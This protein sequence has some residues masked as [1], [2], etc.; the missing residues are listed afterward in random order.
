[1]ICTG[2]IKFGSAG[3][4][5]AGGDDGQ[6]KPLGFTERE[7]LLVGQQ[8]PFWKEVERRSIVA[9]TSRLW[10]VPDLRWWACTKAYRERY[11]SSKMVAAKGMSWPARSTWGAVRGRSVSPW[12]WTRAE[13][14]LLYREAVVAFCRG[15]LVPVCG[16]FSGVGR[17][18]Q[19]WC[20]FGPHT[21]I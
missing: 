18:G 12:C 13:L 6:S 4:A 11:K 8:H 9:V 1:M 14:A 3:P 16:K 2:N 7:Q 20:P 15:T 10:Y 19:A 5:G 17:L 21:T